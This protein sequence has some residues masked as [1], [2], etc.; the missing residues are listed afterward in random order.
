MLPLVDC[1]VFTFCFQQGLVCT[2]SCLPMLVNHTI[3]LVISQVVVVVQF[4]IHYCDLFKIKVFFYNKLILIGDS[5]INKLKHWESLLQ[6]GCAVEQI[7][8]C[9]H[10]HI[11]FMVFCYLFF[12]T[13]WRICDQRRLWRCRSVADRKRRHLHAHFLQLVTQTFS[14]LFSLAYICDNNTLLCL[15]TL[16][17]HS[18]SIGSA[19]S[20]LFV[21]PHLQPV[22]TGPSQALASPSSNGSS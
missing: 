5:L 17:W 8:Q 14:S 9:F 4:W 13:G 21:W 6:P 16:Q 10:F 3:H 15:M 7:V 1:V 19:S 2:S 20:C 22:A 18:S 12:T 11:F